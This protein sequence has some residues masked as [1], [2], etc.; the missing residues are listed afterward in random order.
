MKKRVLFMGTPDF[1]VSLLQV[2]I[3]ADVK[4]VAVISQPDKPV[5]RKQVL[6]STPVKRLAQDHLIPVYQPLKIKEFTQ[7]ICDL[8][9]DL[10]VTCAYG[11]FIPTAILEAPRSGSVN[12]HASLL[13]K[14]RG[15]APIHHALIHGEHESG[16]TLMRMVKQMDAGDMLA[17]V[18]VPITEDD[19]VGSLHDKLKA[20]GAKLLKENLTALLDNQLQGIAQDET[21]VS[22]APN[23]SPEDEFISFKR[24]V[25]TVYDHLRG[26][27][28]WPI[29][30]GIIEGKKLKLIKAFKIIENH[31]DP[32]GK[33]VAYEKGLKIACIG[34]YVVVTQCQAEGKEKM[35]ASA[36]YNGLGKS[37]LNGTFE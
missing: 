25:S 32:I 13:P 33:F 27:S 23:I 26:L 4:V 37:L 8:D 28:P 1:A 10:I 6:S 21:Q 7:F 18:I 12:V 29:G 11:Q 14:Y 30:Y 16:V 19:D 9:L 2:L 17:K 24:N 35:E 3:D 22:F 36:F 15:G 5:G 31:H 34:G 20:A